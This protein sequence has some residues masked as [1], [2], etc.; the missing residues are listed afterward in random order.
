MGN[1]SLLLLILIILPIGLV[2]F[3][4]YKRKNKGQKDKN[5]KSNNHLKNKQ[6]EDEVWLT[7]KRFLRE[8]GETG[9]EVVDSYV[10]KRPDPRIKTKQQKQLAKE[11]KKLK[12][13]DPEAYNAQKAFKKLKNARSLKNY[14][15]FYSQLEILRLLMLIHHE[16]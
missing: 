13:T 5:T 12:K 6:E 1:N 8:S 14:M 3:M 11:F 7:I 2:V 15:L 16:H 9:K 10:V 4:I